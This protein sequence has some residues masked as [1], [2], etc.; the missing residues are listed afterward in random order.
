[1]KGR[2]WVRSSSTAWNEA[3]LSDFAGIKLNAFREI[4]SPCERG[5]AVEQKV[6]DHVRAERQNAV[7]D[8]SRD[9][10]IDIVDMFLQ[11]QHAE[12]V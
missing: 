5:Q 6:A 10:H 8:K 7:A 2:Y 1:M 3:P 9:L 11:R 12:L 4:G